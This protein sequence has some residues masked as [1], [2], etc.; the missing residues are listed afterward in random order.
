MKHKKKNTSECFAN[1]T[2]RMT[3]FLDCF[4]K[5]FYLVWCKIIG[6]A[7][8]VQECIGEGACIAIP[9][10]CAVSMAKVSIG[11]ASG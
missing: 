7:L 10:G 2:R 8:T 9:T 1:Q 11:T 6:I 3:R 5:C 4:V